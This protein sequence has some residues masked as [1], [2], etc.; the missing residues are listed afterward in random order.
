MQRTFPAMADTD[1]RVTRAHAKSLVD[2][3]YSTVGRYARDLRL[4]EAE[5]IWGA[6]LDLVIIIEATETESFGGRQAGHDRYASEITRMRI[7]LDLPA[8]VSMYLT[9]DRNTAT[10]ADT[11]SFYTGGCDAAK[12]LV[13]ALP[14]AYG[15]KPMVK[16]L[17]QEGV[18][19]YAWGV[20]TWPKA[21]PDA[22]CDMVQLA[23]SFVQ[24]K[25][26][27]DHDNVLTN[28][29]GGWNPDHP[30]HA[31]V[32]PGDRLPLTVPATGTD[33]LHGSV[34]LDVQHCLNQWIARHHPADLHLPLPET[35]VYDRA[36]ALYVSVFKAWVDTI[37]AAFHRPLLPNHDTVVANRTMELLHFWST[38]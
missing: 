20:H 30:N 32:N 26:A 14:G 18:A 15:P 23:P 9:T 16:Q 28:D 21:E 36:S 1:T 22:G 10:A 33:F 35:G 5:I 4:A 24:G 34:V 7:Q 3:G 19:A 17:K 25:I 11:R 27:I 2:A 37:S 12:E 6:G 13:Q 38:H 29:I 31:A 8:D